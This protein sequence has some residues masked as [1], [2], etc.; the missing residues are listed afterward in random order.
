M[1]TPPATPAAGEKLE[2]RQIQVLGELNAVV[3]TLEAI[4]SALDDVSN[5]VSKVRESD[6]KREGV[7]IL[8]ALG[9]LRGADS[10]RGDTLISGETHGA[11]L[12][13]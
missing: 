11:D 6:A 5:L 10:R 9:R 13:A 8:L 2:P 3:S 12:N 7:W 4:D 1:S